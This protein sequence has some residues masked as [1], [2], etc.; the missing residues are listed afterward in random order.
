M[1]N[2]FLEIVWYLRYSEQKF[3]DQF[4]HTNEFKQFI[5]KN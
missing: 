1:L 3:I 4:K 2:L 5:Q